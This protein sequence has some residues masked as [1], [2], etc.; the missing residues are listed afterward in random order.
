MRFRPFDFLFGPVV[1][2]SRR[3][4]R[5]FLSFFVAE[6]FSSPREAY[7]AGREAFNDQ[8]KDEERQGKKFDNRRNSRASTTSDG[9]CLRTKGRYGRGDGLARRLSADDEY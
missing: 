4:P 5:S 6:G 7:I 2:G 8:K 9:A 1:A 3:F